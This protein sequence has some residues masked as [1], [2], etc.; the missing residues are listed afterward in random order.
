MHLLLSGN[1]TAV[2]VYALYRV[3]SSSETLCDFVYSK[4]VALGV[5]GAKVTFSSLY[6]FL[7]TE[8]E[9]CQ[10]SSAE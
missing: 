4:S 7:T 8:F 10:L 2:E 6:S 5:I 9:P 3:F 1:N